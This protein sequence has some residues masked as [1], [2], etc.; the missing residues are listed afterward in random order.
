VTAD[1]WLLEHC[2]TA[3]LRI[4]P[5]ATIILYGSRARGNADPMSDYDMLILIDREVSRPLE[6][7]IGDALY[8]IELEQGIVIPAIIFNRDD[9]NQPHFRTLPL[10][11]NIDREGVIV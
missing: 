5:D 11:E 1:T 2:K 9:W 4:V 10:H 8:A 3:V 7:K 6:E